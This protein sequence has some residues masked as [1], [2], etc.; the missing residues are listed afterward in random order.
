MTFDL[1]YNTLGEFCSQ[2]CQTKLFQD[3]REP[4][5]LYTIFL[6]ISLKT[7]DGCQDNNLWAEKREGR[8]AKSHEVSICYPFTS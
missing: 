2:Q 6:I 7:S 5:R 8:E 4:E 3:S 1:K